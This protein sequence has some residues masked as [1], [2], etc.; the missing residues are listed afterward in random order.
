MR[1]R[2]AAAVLAAAALALTACSG[3]S[4]DG[5]DT[6]PT[7]L[8]IATIGTP[9]SFSPGNFGT[10]PTTL[11]L[12]PVY[13][14]LI[15]NDNEG[16]PGANIATEWSYDDT[17]TELTLTLRD[18]VTFTD[19]A[20]LDAE[21]VKANLEFAKQGTGE[22]AGQLRF[23]DSVEATDATHVTITLSAPDSS[24]LPNLGGTAGSLA[25]PEALGTEEL[26][27][28][29][30]GSGPYVLDESASQTGAKYVYTRNKD[31]W[32]PDDFPFDSITATVFN[33]NT[34]ILN[35]LQSGQ[36]DF[37]TVTQKDSASL[38]AAGLTIE[39]FPAYTVSGL[40]LFDREGTIVPALGDVRVRQALNLALDKES[41][42]DVVYGG[43]GTATSQSFSVSSDVFDPALDEQYAYNVEKAKGLLADAGYADGFSLPMP[44]VSPVFPDQQAAVSEALTAIGVTPDYQPVNGETFISDLLS[45]KYPAAIFG[46]NTQRPWD[47][48]QLALTPE[49]LWNTFH[50]ADPTIVSLVDEA[51]GQT[52]EEQTATFRELNEYIVDQAW[53]APYIQSNN[54]F[55]VSS[56]ISVT[57]QKFS[58]VPPIWNFAPA[59]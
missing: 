8:S 27:T 24:L 38:E 45:A 30:V 43:V 41:I 2:I 22:A 50:V 4:T 20:A 59:E 31:Y 51:Q 48:A 56:D 18:D 10:G 14:T 54:L 55:A 21:A 49:A 25:S 3:T 53:F 5:G 13:D 40:Y 47:F 36:V 58:T 32:N 29:P 42:L 52:A 17:Q 23:I 19:G 16:E 44:D 12:Q 7:E 26:N 34:A 37:S 46:L 15:R 9:E 57:P 33:D 6:A 35:A 1:N 39:S 28:Q 11:F